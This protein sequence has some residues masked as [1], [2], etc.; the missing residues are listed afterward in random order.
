MYHVLFIQK[1]CIEVLPIGDTHV[2][3]TRNINK[4]D[5]CIPIWYDTKGCGYMMM[6]MRMMND[7]ECEWSWMKS[8]QMW[9]TW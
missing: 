1:V 3:T 2:E 5:L 8:Q 4:P 7:D 9:R 6:M